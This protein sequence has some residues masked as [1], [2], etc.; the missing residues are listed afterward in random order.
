MFALGEKNTKSGAWRLFLRGG[1][2]KPGE[3]GAPASA[4]SQRHCAR[5]CAATLQSQNLLHMQHAAWY[6][7]RRPTCSDT[8]AFVRYR[9]GRKQKLSMSDLKDNNHSLN[10]QWIKHSILIDIR[11]T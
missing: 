5:G 6:Q 1:N 10:N 2:T 4:L 3:T 8:I 11:D 7:K 9:I